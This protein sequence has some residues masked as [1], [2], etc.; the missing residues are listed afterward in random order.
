MNA[1]GTGRTSA[2][3]ASAKRSERGGR[4][5]VRRWRARTRDRC[6]RFGSTIKLE[7]PRNDAPTHAAADHFHSIRSPSKAVRRPPPAESL[8][9]PN[10]EWGSQPQADGDNGKRS[11]FGTTRRPVPGRCPEEHPRRKTPDHLKEPC[12]SNHPITWGTRIE[13]T[14]VLA[15]HSTCGWED[16]Q[17]P[18]AHTPRPTSTATKSYFASTGDKERAT[19]PLGGPQP[20]TKDRNSAIKF[21]SRVCHP[22]DRTTPSTRTRPAT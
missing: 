20:R 7:P 11:G 21:A 18:Q 22:T 6:Q 3:A 8:S 19:R 16:C 5:L 17:L 12:K 10:S 14:A 1:A 4:A 9:N 15:T 13:R 2:K